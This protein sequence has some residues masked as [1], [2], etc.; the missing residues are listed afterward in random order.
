VPSKRFVIRPIVPF[1]CELV[2]SDE[3][4][5][6]EEDRLPR[7]KVRNRVERLALVLPASQKIIQ[8]F[9]NQ[10]QTNKLSR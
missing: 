3:S 8:N 5:D 6:E 10:S 1:K 7:A 2:A 4:G 9:I